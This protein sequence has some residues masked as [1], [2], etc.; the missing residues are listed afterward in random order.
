MS[1]NDFHIQIATAIPFIRE[2]PSRKGTT[3]R[4]EILTEEGFRK[5]AYIKLLRVEDIAK[6]VLCATLARRLGLP[7]KQAYYVEVDPSR[8]EGRKVGNQYNIAFGLE[9]DYFPTFHIRSDQ[10][11]LEVTKWDD[12]LACAVFDEWILNGDRL[13]N[14]LMF[15]QNGI[16]WLIDHDEALPKSAK[17]DDHSSSQLLQELSKNRSEIELWALRKELMNFV[18]QYELLDWSEVVDFLRID[19][20][21]Q[22][23]SYFNQYI[24]LLRNRIPMMYAV[25]TNSLGIRQQSLILEETKNKKDIIE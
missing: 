16:Y 20:F 13:P 25:I 15:A 11:I 24:D 1:I 21:P 2:Q 17:I 6:E 19:Q 12:A 7:I 5:R 23:E 9:E 10:M 4:G 8:V 18:K 14:N 3:F 22:C